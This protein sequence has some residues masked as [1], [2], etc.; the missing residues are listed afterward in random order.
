MV[1]QT[2]EN[3]ELMADRFTARG[4]S[5][6]TFAGS[7]RASG[8]PSAASRRGTKS[9]RIAPRRP[10]VVRGCVV[11]AFSITAVSW[12][13]CLP[14]FMCHMGECLY[15]YVVV[16]SL[17]AS[18]FVPGLAFWE[19][20]R[21]TVLPDSGWLAFIACTFLVNSLLGFA[22]GTLLHD[23]GQYVKDRR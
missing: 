8:D 4:D 11:L 6:D 20:L 1:S 9:R 17:W 23:I 7:S 2:N 5:R 19:I 18:V 15:T 12:L 10:R 14:I 16:G 13:L 22:V 3:D 21:A